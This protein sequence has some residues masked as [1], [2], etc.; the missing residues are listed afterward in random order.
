MRK[1]LRARLADTLAHQKHLFAHL[2]QLR[3]LSKIGI[4]NVVI[5]G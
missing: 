4:D 3:A 5:D 2:L 1:S